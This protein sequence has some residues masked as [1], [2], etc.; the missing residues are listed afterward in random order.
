[1][2]PRHIVRAV[3]ALLLCIG[4]VWTGDVQAQTTT[5][6]I[7]G[8]VRGPDGEDLA[9]ATVVARQVETNQSRQVVTSASGAFA[10][11]GL[12][13]GTYEV[14]ASRV[15][16]GP[17]VRTV[18]VGVGQTLTA[19]FVLAPQ[20][21]QLAAITATGTRATESR[22]SEVAANVSR[23]QVESLPTSDRNFLSLAQ[24]APGVQL[25][26]ETLDGQRKTFT[27]GAQGADQVNVFID[28]ASYK[29]D[30][31]QGGV[32]GQDASRGSPFPRNA[33]G[34]FRII[35]QNFKAEYQKASSAIITATTRSGTNQWESSAFFNLQNRELIALDR[36]QRSVADT[37]ARYD[38]PEF[39]RVQ[40][41]AD[42][43][44]PIIRDRLHFFG[45]IERNDQTR[46][47]RVNIVPPAGYPALD[48]INFAALNGEFAQPFESWLG[49]GKL[50]WE[51]AENS[52]WEVSYSH[53]AEE[54]IRGFGNLDSYQSATRFN[55][56]VNTGIIKSTWSP[57]AFL[58][59]AMLSV[60]RYRYNPVPND[61]GMPNRFFGFG[62][63]AQLGSNVSDQ[64][65]TQTRYSLRNDLT[66]TGLRMGGDHVV[67]GGVN[68][69]FLDYDIIKRNSEN[70]RFVY[71]PWFNGFAIPQRVEFQTG[72]PNFSAKNTQVGLYLQDD[73]S[74]TSRLVLNLGMRWD[75]ESHMMNY[76]YVTPA[77]IV[78]SLTRYQDRLFRPLNPDRYFTDG[79]DR[80]PFYGA[81]QPRAGFSYALDSKGITSVFGGWG[82][83]YD[84]NLFDNAIE[85]SF[86]L[87]HPSYTIFFAPPGGP[88]AANQVEW[89][90][91]YLTDRNA[92]RELIADQR[93]NTPEVKLLP[94]DLRPPKAQ[95][96]N[97]G[98]RRAFGS[99]EASAAYTGVRSQNVLTF[100]WANQDFVCPE[101]SFGVPDCFQNRGIPGWGTILMADDAGKTWYD[102]LQI[103]VDRPYRG[104]VESGRGWGAGVAVTIAERETQGFNDLFSFAN[105]TDFPRQKRNDEPLR[106][107]SNFI[108]DMPWLWGVQ[109][110][111]L[112]NLGTGT[113]LDIGGRFDCNNASTCF[114]GGGFEPE[115][116]SF[117]IPDAF[118]YRMVDLRLR[119]DFLNVRGS[120][121]GVSAE[122][123]N[124]FNFDNLGCYNT[125]N[126]TDP[127]FG[128]SS[129]TISDPQRLQIGL[130]Y[131]HR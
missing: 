70:P 106:I 122:V 7:Q 71:E 114:D 56:G 89:N 110:S 94:N 88:V 74:P 50:S 60:Q 77:G 38:R 44:G 86:A 2:N 33:I 59:E 127:A 8:Y 35:T 101:R 30:M 58:N 39:E 55:N 112:I 45:S 40:W 91:R 117:I 16:A 1:M 72:D 129:C 87:Q 113:R 108:V 28:G 116:H 31:I 5:G 67:K 46:A 19:S 18:R 76:D 63:C 99:V 27:A 82:I 84:R 22:T 42:I 73:W 107:V 26:N 20:A 43:G 21:V 69:D 48:T 123:F 78:D 53:R 36:F 17:Q 100:Y 47:S 64:D 68:V 121:V 66:W 98:L 96:F 118:A 61:P 103:K 111:G 81:F 29:N 75:V 105:E 41:G 120:A 4:G 80:S 128:R 11:A 95:H 15:G 6:Q 65:F 51:Q 85:E 126:R 62:C 124:V 24:L 97:L 83:F 131:R 52:F 90:E 119:K 3:L 25:Q 109:F 49:F 14:T 9:G 92:L 37:A 125:F 57:G 23:Q 12:R 13:P 102:A 104:S 79:S 32:A 115:K 130:E 34:E 93:F 10:L 54:D